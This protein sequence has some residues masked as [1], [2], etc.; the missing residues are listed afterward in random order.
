M[1]WT[2]NL[3][4]LLVTCVVGCRFA[5]TQSAQQLLDRQLP[6]MPTT[7]LEFSHS[8]IN[9][10]IRFMTVRD[11][12]SPLHHFVFS[13]DTLM[14]TLHI[15]GR[16]VFDTTLY[17]PIVNGSSGLREKLDTITTEGFARWSNP[18]GLFLD[19]VRCVYVATTLRGEQYTI[20]RD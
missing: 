10:D 9:L 6:V 3:L 16:S 7:K 18:Q 12:T 15:R 20:V 2:G 8:G 11:T 17:L 4:L 13:I 14:A 19:S 1:K 5:A